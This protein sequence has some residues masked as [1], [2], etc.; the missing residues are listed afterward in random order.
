M[1]SRPKKSTA[2]IDEVARL[3]LIYDKT[4]HLFVSC[5]S[6]MD[7][8]DIY[9]V[10]DFTSILLTNLFNGHKDKNAPDHHGITKLLT[11]N[12]HT[13]ALHLAMAS[14]HIMDAPACWFDC[15]K[16][17]YDNTDI[18][19][20]ISSVGLTDMEQQFLWDAIARIFIPDV[21]DGSL[22]NTEYATYPPL[23]T[24][25]ITPSQTGSQRTNVTG[26]SV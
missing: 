15:D 12:T 21:E 20:A 8:L 9:T 13:H 3:L 16:F 22:S 18:K 6:D 11:S 25:S 1:Q 2:V 7:L 19:R 24:P 17:Y 10:H 23:R 26:V 5:P 4:C 14:E